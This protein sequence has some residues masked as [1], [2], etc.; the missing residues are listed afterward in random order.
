MSNFGYANSAIVNTDKKEHIYYNLAIENPFDGVDN[1]NTDDC[2]YEKQTPAI[3]QKQSD[4]E[5]CVDSWQ[6][7]AKLPILICPIQEGA[8]GTDINLTPYSVTYE[9]T[10]GGVTTNF[11]TELIYLPDPKFID[12]A[13]GPP[14]NP[15]SQNNGIQDLL[16]NHGYYWLTK[17]N[18]MV[19]MINTALTTSYNAFNAAHGGIHSS[20]CYVQYNPQTGLFSIVGESS[21]ATAA[22][23]AKVYF[24]T[25][26][27]KYIDTIPALFH[28]F[29][30]PFS[31]EFQ[32]DFEVRKG[33]SN[34]WVEGNPNCGVVP[35]P[36][37][38]PPD[39][40][41]MEQETDSR[42]LWS[43]ITQILLTSNSINVRDS[44]LPYRVKPQQIANS[45]FDNFNQ[46]KR[47]VLSYIDYN[48]TR[49]AQTKQSS[50]VR[51]LAYVPKYRKWIDLVSNDGLNNIQ[52]EYYYVLSGQTILPLT[53]PVNG[54]ADVSLLFRKKEKIDISYN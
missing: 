50:L 20:E 30:Q 1:G 28:G 26:L 31:K 9:F 14:P 19:K 44:Y 42:E 41:I 37:T 15:P 48:A 45:I 17:Y 46:P 4:Y 11:K 33:N 23:P 7:R 32:I 22:N 53:L 3:L 34:A 21:Y 49:A 5:L 47:S 25:Q 18:T 43:N 8:T 16:T 24:E 35:N 40:I 51:D 27:Y 52:L 39:F 2:V 38:D 29:N 54:T 6:V 13:K 12:P 36:Q 10:T